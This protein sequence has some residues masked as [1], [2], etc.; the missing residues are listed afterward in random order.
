MGIEIERKFLVSGDAWR[1]GATGIPFRQ[2]YM[3]N[4]SGR[5]IRVRIAGGRAFL[6]IKGKTVGATRTEFEYDL[7]VDEATILLDNFC[8][9]PLIEKVRY[10]VEFAGHTWEIDEFSGD[11]AGL[12]IA[13]VELA[14][15]SETIQLPPWIGEEVTHDPRYYNANLVNHPY[16]L[17]DKG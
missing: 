6:T 11:N 5:T 3:L 15:E 9:G 7:P 14:S 10:T 12:I 16:R 8:N 17:W 4:E 1:E 2:G 13:E